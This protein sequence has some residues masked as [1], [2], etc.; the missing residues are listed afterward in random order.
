MNVPISY[1][2]PFPPPFPGGGG[3]GFVRI[4]A[5]PGIGGGDGEPPPRSSKEF[6]RLTVDRRDVRSWHNIEPLSDRHDPF[7]YA[8]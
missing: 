8:A 3:D 2:P 5:T 1:T 7:V 6:S 4:L